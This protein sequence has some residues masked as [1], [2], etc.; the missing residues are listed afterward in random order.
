MGHKNILP[1]M[2]KS[3]EQVGAADGFMFKD[4]NP[5][6]LVDVITQYTKYTM[7]IIDPNRSEVAMISTRE[8]IKGPDIWI[9]MGSSVG[10]GIKMGTIKVGFS[11][12]AQRLQGGSIETSTVKSFVFRDDPDEVKRIIQ[13]AEKSRPKV[14]TKEEVKRGKAEFD[15]TVE[16]IIK[17]FNGK[18]AD[19]IRQIISCFGNSSAKAIVLGV[20]CQ[21]KKYKKLTDALDR[22]EKDWKEHWAYQL[23]SIAG[24][25]DVFPR[26]ALVWDALYNDLKMPKPSEDE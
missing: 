3:L 26:N 18:D 7:A 17:E 20:V 13:E 4:L 12:Q 9:I 6:T 22:L 25:P 14:K 16:S 2:N 24:N 19:R 5:G 10:S 1:E 8:Q 23:P 11:F 15:F 21:A